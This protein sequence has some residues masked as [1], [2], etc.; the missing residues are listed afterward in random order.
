[1]CV[2]YLSFHSIRYLRLPNEREFVVLEELTGTKMP[3][4]FYYEDKSPSCRAVYLTIS[5]LGIPVNF[6][7]ILIPNGDTLKPEFLKMNPQHLIPTIDDDG[8]HL[9]ESRA[10]MMYLVDQ[11]GRY[12]SLYPKDLKKR[13]LVNQRLFFDA[14]TL[15]RAV[16]DCYFSMLIHNAPFDPAKHELIG[17]ALSF[18]EIF[19]EGKEFTAGKNMT[20]ADLSLMTSVTT[21]EAVAYDQFSKF[22]NITRWMAKMK[23]TA[24]NYEKANQVG[25]EKINVIWKAMIPQK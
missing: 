19:L 24:P 5:A 17:T 25:L 1:M 7:E 16:A 23:K 18:L 21:L 22:P 10:I 4:D 9:W 14:C 20:I 8:F 15:S 13:T 12:D 3:I 2:C 6:K 11:Y